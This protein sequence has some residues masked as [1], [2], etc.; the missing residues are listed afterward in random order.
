MYVLPAE[1]ANVSPWIYRT[2]GHM[3]RALLSGGHICSGKKIQSPMILRASTDM[4]VHP[5]SDA[6][7]A[8]VATGDPR[9]SWVIVKA[10][11]KSTSLKCIYTS[12]E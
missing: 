6:R 1:L 10:V 11:Q 4:P 3:L 7:Q 5:K 8:A 2:Q 9:L 12:R